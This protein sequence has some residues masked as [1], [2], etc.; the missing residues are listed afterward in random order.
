MS[1]LTRCNYCKFEDIKA[2]AKQAGLQPWVR[3]KN[4]GKEAMV[5]GSVVAWFMELPDHCCCD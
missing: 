4:D 2:E 5:G 1:E 3:D